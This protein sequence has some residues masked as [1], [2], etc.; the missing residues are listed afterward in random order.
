MLGGV[1][2]S[3]NPQCMT[4]V[5]IFMCSILLDE[6]NFNP[7]LTDSK[8]L[9]LTHQL[10]ETN[11]F[12]RSIFKII[13]GNLCVFGNTIVSSILLILVAIILPCLY[14]VMFSS[15]MYGK[16]LQG[17]LLILYCNL[18]TCIQ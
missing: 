9:S 16:I 6:R 1:N 7:K 13:A 2:Q 14:I 18:V 15:M 4:V 10:I 5:E 8:L 3:E 11:A 17:L 12:S